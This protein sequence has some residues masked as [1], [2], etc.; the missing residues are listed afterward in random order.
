MVDKIPCV[1]A[2]VVLA[3]WLWV[4][5]AGAVPL[6]AVTASVPDTNFLFRIIKK[7]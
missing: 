5:A 4:A 2:A 7:G 1:Y 3:H 6:A